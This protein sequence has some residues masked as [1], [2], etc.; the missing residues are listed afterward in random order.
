MSDATTM[1]CRH[2]RNVTTQTD[3]KVTAFWDMTPCSSVDRINI[4]VET[5]ASIFRAGQSRVKNGR[6]IWQDRNWEQINVNRWTIRRQ[7]G[8]C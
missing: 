1:P 8:E 6:N 3:I 2:K 5:T 7:L 4:S